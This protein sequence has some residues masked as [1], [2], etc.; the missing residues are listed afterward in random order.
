MANKGETGASGRKT[1]PKAGK[2]TKSKTLKKRLPEKL[3]WWSLWIGV[4][5]L[6]S[7]LIIGIG[8]LILSRSSAMERAELRREIR[9]FEWQ[10]RTDEMYVSPFYEIE[11][12]AL[13]NII[14]YG[15]EAY[16]EYEYDGAIA[17][18]RSAMEL[19]TE[20]DTALDLSLL[21]FI[22]VSQIKSSAYKDAEQTFLEMIRIAEKAKIE[23]APAFAYGNIGLVYRTLG[24]LD[25]ALEYHQKALKINEQIGRLQGQ[26]NQLGNIGIVYQDLGEPEKAL[27]YYE[28][29]LEINKKIGDL[30]GKVKDL[31][32]IGI[33]YQTLGE[34]HKALEYYEQILKIHEK[35]G[36][37]EGKAKDL[38]NIGLVYHT[39]GKPHK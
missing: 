4:A 3:G 2:A 1:S 11:D 29:A 7:G 36:D 28:R 15:L 30:E 21:N 27:E 19:T 8:G 5:G 13:A 33:V 16:R 31:G 6:V 22:G 35:I 9:R 25:K 38:G 12:P 14:T 34:P 26:A 24:E 37:L 17:Y 23:E 39:L 32:N 20:T 18:F 10:G